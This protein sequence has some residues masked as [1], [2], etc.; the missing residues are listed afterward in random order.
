M[1]LAI[2]DSVTPGSALAFLFMC[3]TAILTYL[4]NR[5]KQRFDNERQSMADKIITLTQSHQECEAAHEV[6]LNEL[7]TVRQRCDAAEVRSAK[8][9][10]E[11]A[12][13]TTLVEGLKAE[14][15]RLRSMVF[16]QPE[17]ELTS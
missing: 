6:T 13:L 2:D 8:R 10:G 7:A 9:D 16:R 15:E 1:L 11:I 12:G 3:V 4:N 5:D 17:K 14:M